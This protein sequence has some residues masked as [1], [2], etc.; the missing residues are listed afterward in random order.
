MGTLFRYFFSTLISIVLYSS[1][2]LQL[3]ERAVTVTGKETDI[4]MIRSTGVPR[5]DDVISTVCRV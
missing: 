5:F 1:Y 4:G 2:S 3:L